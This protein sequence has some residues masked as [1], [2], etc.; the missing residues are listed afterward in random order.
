MNLKGLNL[1]EK[2]LE[3]IFRF[4]NSRAGL[5]IIVCICF[6]FFIYPEIK[7][8]R[9]DMT[10]ILAEVK[11]ARSI[12]ENHRNVPVLLQQLRETMIALCGPKEKRN[13]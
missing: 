5:A 3:A 11:E 1:S 9:Q 10:L 4:A 12:A 8:I 7:G 2:E 13:E 6:G